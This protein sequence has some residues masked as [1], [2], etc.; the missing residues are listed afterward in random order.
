MSRL[1]CTWRA[2]F[3]NRLIRVCVTD[4]GIR[5]G[6]RKALLTARMTGPS[7]TQRS[8]CRAVTSGFSRCLTWAESIASKLTKWFFSCIL[9][10]ARQSV[11]HSPND[12][13]VHIIII[14]IIST[15]LAVKLNYKFLLVFLWMNYLYVRS[16]GA[17][18]A[19]HTDFLWSFPQQCFL[20][21]WTSWHRRALLHR[22]SLETLPA[23]LRACP[24]Y[25]STGLIVP[26]CSSGPREQD[27]VRIHP[28]SSS[29]RPSLRSPAGSSPGSHPVVAAVAS[30]AGSV[31]D[32]CSPPWR[33]HH[34]RAHY[35][36]ICHNEY[37]SLCN[38]TW[39][40]I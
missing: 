12:A 27:F 24:V 9:L 31:V 37:L 33:R 18:L 14:I 15:S 11:N 8:R 17:I 35:S 20:V 5:G 7:W 23:P 25:Y 19:Q 32:R 2:L 28:S 29:D 38:P 6:S 3:V 13:C 22:S 39:S 16:K 10:Y 26:L 1:R 34:S 21:T 30:S 36:G 40:R 4:T